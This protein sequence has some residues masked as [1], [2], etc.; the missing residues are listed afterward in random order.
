MGLDAGHPTFKIRVFP[1][2]FKEIMPVTAE[3]SLA[4]QTREYD[5]KIALIQCTFYNLLRKL[6]NSLNCAQRARDKQ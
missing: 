4:R 2:I 1:L 6:Q 3:L 5:K